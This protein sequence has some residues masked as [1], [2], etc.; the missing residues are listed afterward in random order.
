[1]S[2]HNE[3]RGAHAKSV[4]QNINTVYTPYVHD[5]TKSVNQSQ[6]N[7]VPRNVSRLVKPSIISHLSVNE[8]YIGDTM[9]CTIDKNK[10]VLV[11]SDM[12]TGK[13][14]GMVGAIID[15]LPRGVVIVVTHLKALVKGNENRIMELLQ[16]SGVIVRY[17]H[18]SDSSSI[19]IAD[20]QL[21]FTTLHNLHSV[22]DKIGGAERVSLAMFDE[23]ESVAQMMTA[24]IIDKSREQTITALESLAASGCKLVMLDA[25]LDASTYA[26]GNAFIGGGEWVMLDNK[27]QRW[28]GTTYQWIK[29]DSDSK[30]AEKAGIEKV[31]ELLKAGKNVFVT[32]GSKAQANRAYNVLKKLG[33]LNNREVLKAWGDSKELQDCK[34]NH[35]L[36][37]D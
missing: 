24:D 4:T 30:N 26:F 25:H 33:L 18:Y 21:V 8:Q 29:A 5:C 36:F 22:V 9:R 23:S 17:A 32:S 27:Y 20:A 3:K 15:A 13:T 7:N 14:F 11:R 1:M 10:R 28:A 6:A 2:V 34:D 12:G 31:V 16:K 35:D 19:D 37:N